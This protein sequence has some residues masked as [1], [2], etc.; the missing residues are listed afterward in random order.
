MNQSLITREFARDVEV[1]QI[2]VK[3]MLDSRL[4]LH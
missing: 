4:E 2:V 3:T 1:E